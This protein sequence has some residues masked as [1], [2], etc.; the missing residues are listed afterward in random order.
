MQL[1]FERNSRKTISPRLSSKSIIGYAE[2]SENLIASRVAKQ[3]L[4]NLLMVYIFSSGLHGMT[5]RKIK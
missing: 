4:E 3:L 1:Y 5:E 2:F